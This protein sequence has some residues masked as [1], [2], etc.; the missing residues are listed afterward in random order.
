MVMGPKFV[1]FNISMR[2]AIITQFYKNLTRK[3]LLRSGL[4]STAVL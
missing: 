4:D 1:K 2:E 3:H